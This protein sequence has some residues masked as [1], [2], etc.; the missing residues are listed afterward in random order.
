MLTCPREPSDAGDRKPHARRVWGGRAWA[1]EGVRGCEGGCGREGGRGRV[2]VGVGVRVGECGRSSGGFGRGHLQDTRTAP[3]VMAQRVSQ[4]L[5]VQPGRQLNAH[6]GAAQLL[7]QTAAEQVGR[8]RAH[9]QP[10]ERRAALLP[11]Q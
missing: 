1:C 2:R 8:R 10:L 11:Q 9:A 6:V 5:V 4:L 3:R 7:V